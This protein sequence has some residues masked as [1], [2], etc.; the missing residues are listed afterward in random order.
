MILISFSTNF[1]SMKDGGKYNSYSM[2]VYEK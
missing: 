1:G 2:D